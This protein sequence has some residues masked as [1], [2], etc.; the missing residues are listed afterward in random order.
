MLIFS[1]S[2]SRQNFFCILPPKFVLHSPTQPVDLI[3]KA[4]HLK[5]EPINRKKA[6][7]KVTG[8]EKQRV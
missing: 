3:G 4:Q 7:P 1:F 6:A 8:T 2:F 5:V